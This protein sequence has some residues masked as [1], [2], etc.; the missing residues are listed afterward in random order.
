MLGMSPETILL[1]GLRWF[2]SSN[3][4][5]LSFLALIISLELRDSR[6]GR[7]GEK[8]KP[9]WTQTVAPRPRVLIPHGMNSPQLHSH[10]SDGK[11]KSCHE[12]KPCLI[13]PLN[14]A[15]SNIAGYDWRAP[16]PG[17]YKK[18]TSDHLLGPNGKAVVIRP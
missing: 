9:F 11:V 1:S 5:P 3:T 13:C 7:F 18:Q 10:L 15:V 12:S 6:S 14:V 2:D 4:H 8:G 16:G 17:R